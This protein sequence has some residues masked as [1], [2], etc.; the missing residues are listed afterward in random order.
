[1]K[2]IYK[3]IKFPRDGREHNHMIEWWYFNGHLKDKKGN[4]YAFMDCLFRVNIKKL[5]VPFASKAP[6]TNFYFAH[7]IVS[8]IKNK[9]TNRDIKNT[10]LVSKDSF[11]R[12]LLFVNYTDMV[13][14][15]GYG[16]SAI[17]ETKLFNYRIKND[18]LDLNLKTTKNP[19]LESGKGF[20]NVCGNKSFYYSLTN[21]EASGIIVMG[22]KEIEVSGKA[23]MDHQWTNSAGYSHDKWNWFSIQLDNNTEIVMTEFIS[24][25]KRD[26]WVDIMHSNGRQE[27]LKELKLKPSEIWQ[28]KDTK[29]KYP[30]RWEIEIP[31]K[32]A[33]LN[34]RALI[35]DQEVHAGMAKYWEGPI[36]VS[37]T[38]N[39][40]KVKGV[41]FMELVGRI[42]SYGV[43]SFE[44]LKKSISFIF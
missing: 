15:H 11:K 40:K 10:V 17:E 43:Y 2:T 13:P 14:V 27:S 37:G 4:K 5:E 41:G 12:P 34:V 31:G 38:F 3:P 24:G 18:N 19:L 35:K 32:K 30:L 44:E 23:W 42:S 29:E 9:K 6:F 1:M 36:E 20:T 16:N 7:S 33:K 28:S 22:G 25:D 21:M 26:S 39:G 8:D